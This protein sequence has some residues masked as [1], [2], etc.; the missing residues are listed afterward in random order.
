[1]AEIYRAVENHYTNIH[2]TNNPLHNEIVANAFGYSSADLASIP[3]A[4]NLGVSCGNPLATANLKEVCVFHSKPNGVLRR[5]VKGETFLDLGS[6]G[7]LDV[8]LASKRVG[9]SGKCIGVDMND[10]MLDLARKNAAKG[11]YINVEFVSLHNR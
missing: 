11:G 10:K 4:A 5:D 8:F 9:P 3:A 6:G 2:Y 1:M 7:G